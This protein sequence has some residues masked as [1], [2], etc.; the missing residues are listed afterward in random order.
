MMS[1]HWKADWL[2]NLYSLCDLAAL[3]W[4][5][6]PK[7][8]TGKNTHQNH[9]LWKQFRYYWLSESPAERCQLLEHMHDVT[10]QLPYPCLKN[11][12]AWDWQDRPNQCKCFREK[13]TTGF[14]HSVDNPVRPFHFLLPQR[15]QNLT[16]AE[17]LFL[18]AV[19]FSPHKSRI[20]ILVPHFLTW[21]QFL[22]PVSPCKRKDHDSFFQFCSVI[23]V[24]KTAA[25]S[26]KITHKEL[27][28]NQKASFVGQG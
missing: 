11:I 22:H 27:A 6:S 20:L 25:V 24:A 4:L 1:S 16:L 17:T 12:P 2:W 13:T 3:S 21:D 19:V 8:F 7:L 23:C 10:A 9:K 18:D 5:V 26:W 14:W 28:W 15:K